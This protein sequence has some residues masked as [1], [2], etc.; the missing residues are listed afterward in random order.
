MQSLKEAQDEKES[1]VE[2]DWHTF[3]KQHF[4]PED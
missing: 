4:T 3:S 1:D 2:F